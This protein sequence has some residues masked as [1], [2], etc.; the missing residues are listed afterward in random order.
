MCGIA[1][2][3]GLP[4]SEESRRR[5]LEGMCEAMVHRGPDGS[6]FHVG[7][8]VALGMRRLSVIDPRG[9]QQPLSSEDGSILLV[10][11][12]E[13][14]NYRELRA[15]LQS[16]GHEFR[17]DGDAESVVH[18]YEEYGDDCV[19]LPERN[20]RI[21]PVGQ[22]PRKAAVGQGSVGDQ[23]VVPLG[24]VHGWIRFRAAMSSTPPGFRAGGGPRLSGPL[25]G[26]GV[27]PGP[28]VDLP[29]RGEAAARARGHLDPGRR[30]PGARVLEPRVR[31]GSRPR[32]RVGRPGNQTS[33]RSRGGATT[34]GGRAAGSVPLGGNRLVGGR[35][36]DVPID[37]PASEDL[38]DRV[39]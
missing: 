32:R 26:P 10:F 6:G 2:F 8:D 36:S 37:G 39:P 22:H 11:N 3:A 7:S 12:G 33:A 35:R 25:P 14:Y 15:D 4:G 1:G 24:V 13:V 18:L 21:R 9:S 16:R 27:C 30:P 19:R 31:G 29:W 28:P 23:A 17:T 34:G 5:C 38:L 20:V